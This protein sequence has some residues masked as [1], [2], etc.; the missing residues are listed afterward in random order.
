MV[1]PVR[2]EAPLSS[3]SDPVYDRLDNLSRQVRRQWWLF[4]TVL[5][6]MVL[7]AV[8]VRLLLDRHPEAASASAFVAADAME[9]AKRPGAL[10]AMASADGQTA[11]F[12]ARAAIELIQTAL[13]R[14]D[15]PK[16][17]Q[18]AELAEK[19]AQ[20][21]ADD[22]LQLAARLSAAAIDLQEGKAEAAEKRYDAVAKAAGLRFPVRKLDADI[23]AARALAAQGRKSEAA[24]RLEPLLTR[25]DRNAD[26]LLMLAKGMYWRFLREAEAEA[27]AAKAMPGASASAAPVVPAPAPVSVAPA[28]AAPPTP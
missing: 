1:D 14:N 28:P 5:V 16:A 27:A 24:A 25:S 18:W 7:G 23:G 2:D 26:Y 6:V 13:E 15:L 8:V 10:E 12:R 17:R 22:D 11:F 9:E 21:S 4:A 3:Y 20:A 19:Q